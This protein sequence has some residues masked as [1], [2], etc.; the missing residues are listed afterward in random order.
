MG[1]KIMM[2]LNI[3]LRAA[4][5]WLNPCA[6]FDVFNY[7]V[8]PSPVASWIRSCDLHSAAINKIINDLF[9]SVS[10]NYNTMYLQSLRQ[11]WSSVMMHRVLNVVLIRFNVSEQNQK[12]ITT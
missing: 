6:L 7:V 4:I 9:I 5:I 12:K 8:F 1:K 3:F 11:Y 10:V 2:Q